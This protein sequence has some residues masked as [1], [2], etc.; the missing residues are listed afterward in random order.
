MVTGAQREK[1]LVLLTSVKSHVDG[2]G[3]WAVEDGQRMMPHVGH[4]QHLADAFGR[5]IA[6]ADLLLGALFELDVLRDRQPSAGRFA[7]PEFAAS[8]RGR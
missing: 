4:A 5:R 6:V 2:E 8:R 3:G 7:G 1:L